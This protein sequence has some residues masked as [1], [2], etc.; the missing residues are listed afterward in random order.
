MHILGIQKCSKMLR[1]KPNK[2]KEEIMK[3]ENQ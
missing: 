1:F 3:R 2:A